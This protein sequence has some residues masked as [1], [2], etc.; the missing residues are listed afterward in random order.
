MKRNSL[1][2]YGLLIV[3]L[4][5]T[6]FSCS[7]NSNAASFKYSDFNWDELMEKNKDFWTSTCEGKENCIDRVLKTKEKFY[8]RLYELLVKYEKK[9]YYGI[10]DNI[11]IA[12]VFYG[13]NADSFSDPSNEKE[14]NPYLID[15]DESSKDKYL[16]GDDGDINS[17]ED[18]FNKERDSLKTLINNFIGY[19]ST[20]YGVSGQTPTTDKN[21]NKSCS[22]GLMVY[23]DECVEKL[24]TYRGTFFDS[25][26]LSLFGNNNKKKCEEKV[27]EAGYS[28]YKFDVSS[29]SEVNDEFFYEFLRTSTYF[30]K[31]EHLQS[32]F[33]VVLQYSGY[34]NMTK[35]YENADEDV[36]QKF[37]KEI[38]RARES[39]IKGI[40]SIIESY[41]EFS[42]VSKTNSVCNSNSTYWW[43]IGGSD[44][45][46]SDGIKM[47]IGDPV[48]T[49]INSKFGIREGS[50]VVSSNHRGI[51]INGEI[52][53]TPVIAA[54]S[55]TVVRG[56]VGGTGSCT[57]GDTE[58]GGRFG[59]YVILQHTDGNYT[60]Y[61][62]MDTDSVIV[63]DGDTVSQGQVIG[64]VGSTGSST[65]GHLHFEV[66]VAGNDSNSAQDPL[67]FIN[68]TNPRGSS[69]CGSMDK[70]T[71]WVANMEGGQSHM[72]DDTHYKVVNIG[73]GV[74]T[75]GSGITVENNSDVIKQF[76][77]NPSSLTLG[78]CVEVSVA[79]Q[80][81]QAVI[82]KHMENM[83]Q[84]SSSNGIT[85]LNDNQLAAL[86]SLSFNG[87]EPFSNFVNAYKTYG[88][89]EAL[90]TNWWHGYHL[91]DAKGTYYPGLASRRKAECDLFVNGNYIMNVY[92]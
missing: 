53:I 19:Q 45:T 87:I 85:N 28:S 38:V 70:L 24:E 18:Y 50:S 76:G 89:T 79:D 51:D 32:Y 77:L 71:E 59:N 30:D 69:S 8:K 82:K 29:N 63:K 92:G 78:S 39:I 56:A 11:I 54:E 46:D 26:G 25:I 40:K 64:Y 86:T 13:L 66:R 2:N 47:A 81:Y 68:E 36:Q 88:S 21:G 44:I 15:E 75:F 74:R 4:F 9:G 42:E 80:I 23:G 22:Q 12:T 5:V 52:G 62:H 3:F 83:K 34:E 91:H 16:A 14:Y 20:C 58:C 10:N 67:N 65:G 61:A 43:P 60:V 48:S 1:I 72:C 90:C 27:R 41:G 35:F 33:D 37:E 49:T 17:A 55:G 73:D 57:Q 31:K 7:L 6:F 84:R